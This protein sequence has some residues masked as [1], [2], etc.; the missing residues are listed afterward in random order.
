M[1]GAAEVLAEAPGKVLLHDGEGFAVKHTGPPAVHVRL[2]DGISAARTFA[3]DM[4]L[5]PLGR[6]VLGDV[7]R[8]PRTPRLEGARAAMRRFTQQR[9]ALPRGR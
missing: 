8:R 1:T 7:P 6:Q 2:A 5:T 3:A 4:T 9:P